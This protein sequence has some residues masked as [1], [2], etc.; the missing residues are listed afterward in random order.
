MDWQFVRD[1]WLEFLRSGVIQV[2]LATFFGVLSALGVDRLKRRI[3][4]RAEV[5]ALRNALHTTFT[6]NL[7]LLD[8]VE[9]PL[10]ENGPKPASAR[11]VPTTLLDTT[12]LEA[13]AARKYELL[14]ISTCKACDSALFCLRFVNDDIKR[15]WE[16]RPWA[17]DIEVTDSYFSE[18]RKLCKMRVGYARKALEAAL[19]ALN[20]QEPAPKDAA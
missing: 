18:L 13:T 2:F 20:A 4:V 15:L 19:V 3:Q 16:M 6:T 17:E 1:L 5:A 14:G 12:I 10:S 7:A 8:G 11:G 9:K